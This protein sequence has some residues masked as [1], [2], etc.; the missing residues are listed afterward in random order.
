LLSTAEPGTSITVAKSVVFRYSA[1][2]ELTFLF[3]DFRSMCN[4]AI[5]VAVQES[6]KNRFKLI[7]LAYNRLK[8]Y[9]LHTHYI[10]S[11]CEV[12]FSAYKNKERKSIPCIR[13]AFLKLD[14]QSY[15]LNHLL[16]RIPSSPKAF[17]Y[18]K[19]QGS[20]YHLA[21][22]DDSSLKRGSVTINDRVVSIA[23]SKEIVTF[24]PAGFIGVDLNERNATASS[25]D[26]WCLRFNELGQVAEIQE[27]YREI[28][29][30]IGRKTRGDRRIGKELM[31]KYGRR[32]KNRTAQRIHIVTSRIVNYAKEHKFGVKMEKLSGIRKLYRKGNG[33]RASFRG[34][35]NTWVFGETQRQTDYKSKWEGVPDWFINPRGTSSYCLCGSRVVRL[36][37]RKLYCQVCDKTWDRDVLA[38]K[39]IMACAVPQDRPS[40]GNDEGESWKQEVAG[41]P[42]SRWKEG[43]PTV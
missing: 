30:G 15:R 31:S 9:G 19:L 28:R 14:N 2:K 41:N 35:M 3:E 29:A 21:M 23:F 7:E 33:Q 11:A 40:K 5:R 27:R 32:E 39:N 36:A 34:R 42:R 26:G 25:T 4:D 17:I 43:D 16:L 10:L 12:A 20:D 1:S 24:K 22:V 8:Q 18:L 13:R 37:G 38:S 6:P